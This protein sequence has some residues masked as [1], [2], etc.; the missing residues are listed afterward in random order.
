[1]VLSDHLQGDLLNYAAFL[2]G[3]FLFLLK[4]SGSAIRNPNSKFSRRR[5]Y[6]HKNWDTAMI[7]A[8]LEFPIFYGWRHY[9]LASVVAL[10]GWTPPA[11]FTPP[12][13]PVTALFLGYAADSILDWIAQSEKLPKAF[14][15][16]LAESVPKM[17]GTAV[18]QQTLDKAQLAGKKAVEQAAKAV[19]AVA[20]AKEQV[21]DIKKVEGGE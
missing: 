6:F 3:Q 8:A 17:D 20:V 15:K 1:M 4:R 10:I 18:I 11:W 21:A 7:R 12:D 14:R 13:N 9:S 2:V 5:D 16:M 19:D